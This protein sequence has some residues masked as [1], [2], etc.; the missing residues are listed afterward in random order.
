V[1]PSHRRPD[2]A[3]TPSWRFARRR[4]IAPLAVFAAAL[5]VAS[6]CSPSA[7]SATTA[8]AASPAASGSAAPE[9]PPGGID[10]NTRFTPLTAS[11]LT[12]PQ[13]VT[14]TDGKL[15]L[16]YELLL[17]NAAATTVRIDRI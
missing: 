13:A 14:G 5:L 17:T 9:V 8:S 4:R 7:P 16:A 1:H 6:G 10:P 11:T 15:H 2:P 12:T 3:L